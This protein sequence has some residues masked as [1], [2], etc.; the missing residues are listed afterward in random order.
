MFVLAVGAA[1]AGGR[2]EGVAAAA[3][4]FTLGVEAL[5]ELSKAG[6]ASESAGGAAAAGVGL[7]GVV[8]GAVATAGPARGGVEDL[9][10]SPTGGDGALT[11]STGLFCKR[12]DETSPWRFVAG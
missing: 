1:Q 3:A 2:L 6:L 11:S 9:G 8:A 4:M 12:T 10:L 5:S 7:V